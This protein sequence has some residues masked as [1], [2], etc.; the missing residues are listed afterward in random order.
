ME[1]TIST[2]LSIANANNIKIIS[3]HPELGADCVTGGEVK[4]ALKYFRSK[5][6]VFTGVGKTDEEI[7]YAVE[8][9]IF[10]LNVESL[11][12][13]EKMDEICSQK[14]KKVVISR[15]LSFTAVLMISRA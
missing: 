3:S 10:C 11:E 13:L 6:L 15:P 12:E 8:N 14:K 4:Y 1:K 9:S 5:S 7:F 2:C